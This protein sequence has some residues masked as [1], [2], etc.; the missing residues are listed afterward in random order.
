MNI[1]LE[2]IKRQVELMTCAIHSQK[3]T[4]EITADEFRVITC[5]DDFNNDVMTKTNEL[6][7][8]EIKKTTDNE[9]NEIFKKFK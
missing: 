1:N 2:N 7:E 3:A 6:I 8:V 4:F 9:L 5:C